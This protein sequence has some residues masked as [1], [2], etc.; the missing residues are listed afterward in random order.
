MEESS[1]R[2]ANIRLEQQRLE[3]LIELSR[4]NGLTKER[5]ERFEHFPADESLVGEQCSVCLE[6]LEIEMEMV[7]LDCHVSHYV[8]KTCADTWFKD[9]NSCPTCRQKFS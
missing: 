5:I 3:R 1:R 9:N 2:L 4:N 7:R 6:D 8:C